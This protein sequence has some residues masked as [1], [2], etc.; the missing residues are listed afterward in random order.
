MAYTDGVS[1][2]LNFEG[3]KFGKKRLR[4]VVLDLLGKE[5]GATA[6]RVVEHIYWELRQF[7]GLR[8]R[9]DD[10]TVVVVRVK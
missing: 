7:G 8:E 2:T 6:A 5:P 1:D 10:Q 4:G 3:K 9:P